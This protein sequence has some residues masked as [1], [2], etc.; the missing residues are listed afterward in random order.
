M[1]RFLV[2]PLCLILVLCTACDRSGSSTSDGTVIRV[3]LENA[4]GLAAN[5]DRITI[6]GEKEMLK[7]T[8]IDGDGSFSFT[9][10]QG[11]EDGLYQIR[12]GAQ[13]A[14]FAIEAEDREIDITGKVSTFSNYD[15][16]VS[17]SEA[18]AE[19]VRTINRMQSLSGLPELKELVTEVE[20]PYTAAFVTFN[21]LLRAGEQGLPLHEAA[22]ARLPEEADSYATYSTYVTQLKQQ[23]AFQKS[24]QLIKPGQPAPNLE[25][26]DPEGNTVSLAD[27]KGQVVLLDFW[28][29]WCAPCRRENPNVVKVYDRYKDKGFTIYSVSL[30][31]VRPEQAARFTPEELAEATE[32]QRKKWVNAIAEDGLS[33]PHHGSELLSWGG[34][35]SAKY[36]VQ[37]IPATF[38]I[39]REGNIAEIGLRGAASIEQALQKVL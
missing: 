18:A 32:N 9:F 16:E 28:A 11:L 35:A 36:G 31:G 23:I 39:D 2:L 30:D 8:S 34:E 6:G 38:L 4:N 22:V 21:A 15:V 5:L 7:S 25:L 19:S 26:K 37:A 27:L 1:Y 10:P 13:K 29:A 12:V 24:Q 20:N 3:Q 14:T 17:G 33:W